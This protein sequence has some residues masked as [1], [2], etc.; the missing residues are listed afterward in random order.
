MSA[1][2]ESGMI[3]PSTPGRV[4]AA[5]VGSQWQ[6]GLI[7]APLVVLL[8]CQAPGMKM[9]SRPNGRETATDVG[10]LQVTL[11]A[12]TPQ[13]VAAKAARPPFPGDPDGLL[14]K[15]FK[16]Y[17]IGPQDVLLATVWDHPEISLPMGQYRTDSTS[18]NTVD[19]DGC[20]FFPFVGRLKVAAMTA[21]EA[22]EALTAQLAKVLRNP[23]VDVKIV[24]YR[25]QKIYVGGE[26]RNPAVYPVTDVPFTLAEAVNRAGGFLA[27]ADDSRMLLTRGNRSWTL[28]FHGLLAA[29]NQ[30]GQIVLQD[31]DAL[32]IPNSAEEPVY[33]MGELVRPGNVAMTHGQLSLARAI[34]EAGGMQMASAD[35][36][37]IY[38]LRQGGSPGAVEV[39]HLD[40]RNP[41]AMVLADQFPLNARD[42][43]YVDSGTLVRFNRVMNLLLPT[44]NATT[45]AGLTAAQV[46]YFRKRL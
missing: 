30:I 33:L 21:S 6:R 13:L 29:G 44:F 25:S 5:S 18:G 20:I 2:N 45:N 10:G 15:A 23:Q 27:S 3:A 24:A 17:R 37:S 8:G 40:A 4:A 41:A 36:T 26:V 22:R 12:L 43:V 9:T 42:I 46:Y 38:V 16:P 19:E 14:V 34:S 39:F 1:L 7:L 28:N 32:Q 35:A 11:H 31:G